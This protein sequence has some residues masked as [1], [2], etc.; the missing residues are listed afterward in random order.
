EATIDR[1]LFKQTKNKVYKDVE[2]EKLSQVIK[3]SLEDKTLQLKNVKF[4]TNYYENNGYRANLIERFFPDEKIKL[5]ADHLANVSKHG[6]NPEYF[7]ANEYLNLLASV[8]SKD[9]ITT[10]EDAY[11]QI[12]QLE[13]ATADALL[14][15]SS[16][17]EFGIIN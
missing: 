8:N 12:A 6:L 11:Q 2:E 14:N 3:T 4:I 17:L 9:G 7:H 13:L 16:A 5:L 15:Y 1:I 10:L